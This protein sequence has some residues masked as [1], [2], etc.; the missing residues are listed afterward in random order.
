MWFGMPNWAAPPFPK[1][2]GAP[3]KMTVVGTPVLILKM[4]PTCHPPTA[5]FASPL[6]DCGVGRA[7]RALTDALWATLKS[8]SP[9]SDLGANQNKEL[10]LLRNVSP[11]MVEELSSIDF[12]QV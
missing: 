7:Q 10:R 11:A 1:P 4:P 8:E 5:A 2:I 6:N 9:R 12:D 3:L